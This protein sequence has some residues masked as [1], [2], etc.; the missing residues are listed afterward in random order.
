MRS[1]VEN[2]YSGAG[3][4]PAPEPADVI[5]RAPKPSITSSSSF[6][7]KYNQSPTSVHGPTQGGETPQEAKDKRAKAMKQ[8]LSHRILFSL[9]KI[10]PW[11]LGICR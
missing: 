10:K 7:W 6:G 9:S 2:K 5:I 4:G 3:W 8:G 1:Q 11:L